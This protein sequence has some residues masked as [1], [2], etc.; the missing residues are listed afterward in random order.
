MAHI[1]VLPCA[2]GVLVS[3]Y[4]DTSDN[5]VV[6]FGRAGTACGYFELSAMETMQKPLSLDEFKERGFA[7]I[8]LNDGYFEP[9]VFPAFYQARGNGHYSVV[10]TKKTNVIDTW[11]RYDDDEH[12]NWID[13]E[14]YNAGWRC[15]EK[16][17]TGKEREAAPWDD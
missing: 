2:N 3:A 6:I 12:Q 10:L 4:H 7:F 1:K 15:W 17:P 5:T 8:E 9:Y 11:F 14:E 13:N 16:E